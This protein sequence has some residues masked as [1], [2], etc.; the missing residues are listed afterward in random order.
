M[1]VSKTND[2]K[3]EVQC[4]YKASD[5]RRR[6]RHKRGF[7]TKTAARK[8]E[9][10]F[11]R[12]AEGSPKMSFGR[13]YEV[14]KAD[15]IPQLKLNTWLTKET[16]IKKKI[17]PYFGDM[18]L[19]E[20]TAR[21]IIAWQNGLYEE[22]NPKTGQPYTMTYL[23][24]VTNQLSAILNHA[25]KFY[26]LKENPYKSVDRPSKKQ[27]VTVGFW[28]KDEYL[29]F[30]DAI[31]DRPLSFTAF[32]VLYYTGIREGELLALTPSDF[33]FDRMVLH[34]TKS[35]QRLR[36]ED[37]VTGPKTPKSV[38]TIA[39]PNFLAAE[40]KEYLSGNSFG[41]NDRMFPVNKSYL[42]REMRRGSKA[43][44]V[45]TIR[46]HDLRR[47]HV[48]LLID[49]GF[50]ALAIADRMGH[51]AVDITYRYADLFPSVQADMARALENLGGK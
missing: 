18:E 28:T 12:K 39:I 19:G 49:L 31:M 43:A 23:R 44:G 16:I 8:W 2:G 13:F 41:P 24:T 10:D 20:I 9:R 47:S 32:E 46:V 15:R 33:D 6:K 26:G 3:W 22:T 51:E 30:S 45:K 40:V 17:L 27:P 48:S 37:V 11:L 29:R 21:D 36:G 25:V 5:G 50:N 34:I 35:Y 14:Y 4:W 1:A 38:R 42:Y 7:T